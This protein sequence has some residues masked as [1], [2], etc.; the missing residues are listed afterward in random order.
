MGADQSWSHSELQ[1]ALIRFAMNKLLLLSLLGFALVA[2]SAGSDEQDSQ[3]SLKAAAQTELKHSR[4]VRAA[5]PNNNKKKSKKSKKAMKK[6]SKKKQ[7]KK[8]KKKKM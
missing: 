5:D 2:L 8:N 4:D 3:R 7:K 1:S 6:K